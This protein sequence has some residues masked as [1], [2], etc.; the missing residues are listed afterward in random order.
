MCMVIEIGLCLM[1]ALFA[2]WRIIRVSFSKVSIARANFVL[3]VV[4]GDMICF[5]GC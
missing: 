1:C 3:F 4:V 2:V 5:L